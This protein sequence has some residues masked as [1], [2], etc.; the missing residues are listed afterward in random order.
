MTTA[1]TPSSFSSAHALSVLALSIPNMRPPD[2]CA[3]ANNNKSVSLKEPASIWFST[4]AR[5]R[6]V[7]PGLL[8]LL[9]IVSHMEETQYS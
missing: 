9:H 2:V 4:H 7:P 6:R 1:A 5:L 3:S 8:H